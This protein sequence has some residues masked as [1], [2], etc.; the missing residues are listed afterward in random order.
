MDGLAW[1]SPVGSLSSISGLQ[2]QSL[3]FCLL[4]AVAAASSSA[5]GTW[6]LEQVA[7]V[8]LIAKQKEVLVIIV[9]E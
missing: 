3:S 1:N 5:D 6:S 4:S 9:L 8:V 7:L 2:L